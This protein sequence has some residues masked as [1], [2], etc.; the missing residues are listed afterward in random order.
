MIQCKEMR[1]L[2]RKSEI[3]MEMEALLCCAGLFE[4][5]IATFGITQYLNTQEQ[6]DKSKRASRIMQN[7]YNNVLCPFK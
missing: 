3:I 7:T 4:T 2:Q 6:R 5:F 1:R